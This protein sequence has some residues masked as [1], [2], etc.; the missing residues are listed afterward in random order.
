MHKTTTTCHSFA[1]EECFFPFVLDFASEAGGGGKGNDYKAWILE[2]RYV[3]DDM[4]RME[5]SRM[6]RQVVWCAMG[7][8]GQ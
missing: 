4:W 5:S 7:I 6:I 3:T 8:K 1:S 2:D